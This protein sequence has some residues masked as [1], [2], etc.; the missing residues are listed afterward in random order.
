M[1]LFTFGTFI[2]VLARLS[3]TSTLPRAELV[4]IYEDLVERQDQA[5]A[6]TALTRQCW[7]NGYSIATNYDKSWPTTGKVVSY[8]LE[9][10]NTTVAP[11]GTPREVFVINGQFPGPVITAN[12]GDTLQIAVKN[13]LTNNGTQAHSAGCVPS[14]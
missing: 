8:N 13:S 9:I 7:S 6:N 5:C 14:C 4:P 2:L 12:W 11:D 3:L 1:S 10:T